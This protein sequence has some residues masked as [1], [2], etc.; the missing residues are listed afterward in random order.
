MF[1]QF[2]DEAESFVRLRSPQ[3]GNQSRRSENTR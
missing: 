1:A 3:N 2:T